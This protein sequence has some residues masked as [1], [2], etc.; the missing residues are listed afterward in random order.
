M[1]K[2]TQWACYFAN[3]T[4]MPHLSRFCPEKPKKNIQECIYMYFT[5]T[6]PEYERLGIVLYKENPNLFEFSPVTRMIDDDFEVVDS[7]FLP[8]T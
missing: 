7:I 4:S 2:W 1:L 8:S 3:T 6:Y 5:N